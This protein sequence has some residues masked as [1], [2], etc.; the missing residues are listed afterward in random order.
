MFVGDG[1]L[2]RARRPRPPADPR[3]A[4]RGRAAGGRRRRGRPGGVRHHAAGGVPAPAGA[5]GDRVRHRASGRRPSPVR[6]PG[7]RP[8]GRRRVGRP[9]PAVLDP[10]SGRAG[11]RAG[12]GPTS[13]KQATNTE[14]SE[15]MIDVVQQINAVHRTVA[16]RA[17]ETGGDARTVTLTQTYA[18]TVE[19]LWDACTDP[20]RIPRWFLPVS[21]DLEVGG[22]YQLE[23]NAGGTITACDPPR[24]FEAT[25][26]FDGKVSWIAV[27]VESADGGATLMLEHSVPVDEIGRA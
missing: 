2:G 5:A 21:G 9:V 27:A 15:V 12:A 22:R 16:G 10:T 18:A 14:A 25:W 17:V 3:A 6:R 13:D 23:G 26:E 4:R 8:A 19:E 24:R 1:G 20:E 7:G 11:D